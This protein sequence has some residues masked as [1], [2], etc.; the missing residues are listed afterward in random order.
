[1]QLQG[2][3][4]A[5]EV[6][7]AICRGRII[8]K[9]SGIFLLLFLSFYLGGCAS[10]SHW[11]KKQSA[12]PTAN[13]LYQKA[14]GYFS[15]GRYVLAQD[16]FK[17]IQDQFPFSPYATLASL[18]YADCKFYDGDYEEAIPLYEEFIRLHPANQF[19]P[20]ALF[21]EGSCYFNLMCSPDRDQTNTHKTIEIYERLL[22]QFPNTPY[23]REVIRRISIARERLAEHELVVANWYYRTNQLPQAIYRCK[24]LMAHYPNTPAVK[25][26][27]VLL[28]KVAKRQTFLKKH[29]WY[30]WYNL[31]N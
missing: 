12:P 19:V 21:Q 28:K 18:Y 15:H 23:K 2:I 16:L 3:L 31:F 6:K 20:Y 9:C 29:K 7:S 27:K 22:N 14:M 4:N 8:K 13:L 24:Y 17:Q 10:I 11:F 25:K 1:M 30:W 26:A 5:S